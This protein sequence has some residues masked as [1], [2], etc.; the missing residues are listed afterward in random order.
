MTKESSGGRNARPKRNGTGDLLGAN[1]EIARKLDEY[2]KG[3][4]SPEIPE[5]LTQLLI[6]LEQAESEQKKG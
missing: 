6:R 5:H 2:F 1:T 4:V 3:L